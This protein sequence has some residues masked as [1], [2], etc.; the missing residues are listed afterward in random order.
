M[1]DLERELRITSA[2]A[3]DLKAYLLSDTL[4]WPLSDAGPASFPYPL[5]T[6]GGLLL[7]LRKLEAARDQL[8]PDQ[9]ARFQVT[10]DKARDAL[11]AWI[12][13]RE[14]KAAREIKARLQT[15]SAFLDDLSADLSRFPSEYATQ[16]EGRTIIMMLFPLAGKAADG[17]GYAARLDGLDGRL[18][19]VTIGGE[20]VWDAIFAPG[21]PRNEHWWLYVQPRG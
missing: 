15:W 3:G 2:S 6:I 16:V 10:S 12:V 19:A 18:K 14:Q 17:K 5:G 4:Y 1:T 8:S 13:Q 11:A 21:F 7:R 9:Y 20:F